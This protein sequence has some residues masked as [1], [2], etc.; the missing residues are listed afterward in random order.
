MFDHNKNTSG[1]PP[2]TEAFP[3]RLTEGGCSNL[4][5]KV[6]YINHHKTRFL[7]FPFFSHQTIKHGTEN[8]Q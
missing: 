5:I 3:F 1:T 2:E 8:A 6:T 4:F 7:V